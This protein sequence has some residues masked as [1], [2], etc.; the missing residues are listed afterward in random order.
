MDKETYNESMVDAPKCIDLFSGCGGFTCGLAK[1]GFNVVG[2]VEFDK[3]ANETYEFNKTSHGFPNS[4]RI[5]EDITKITDEEILAFK[6]KHGEI[7]VIV[8]GPPCQSFS[9]AG[10]RKLDDPRN[11]LFL[12]FVRFVKLIQ[13]KAFILENVPGLTSKKNEEGEFMID[14]IRQAF[15]KIGYETEYALINCANYEVPQLRRRIIIMGCKDKNKIAFP[16]PVTMDKLEGTEDKITDRKKQVQ[17]K[18]CQRCNKH[19]ASRVYLEDKT[20]ICIFCHEHQ[21]NI[22][23]NTFEPCHFKAGNLVVPKEVEVPCTRYDFIQIRNIETRKTKEGETNFIYSYYND[24]GVDRPYWSKPSE[25]RNVQDND[26]ECDEAEI[27]VMGNIIGKS[28]AQSLEE[29][30]DE[31]SENIEQD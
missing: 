28:I 13:P 9:L 19:Y 2:H 7:P 15:K 12:H 26:Q 11:N 20:T 18:R 24:G 22:D 14:I 8:G 3:S 1:A 25:Y 5:G 6:E 29:D 23:N 21:K 31:E 27:F 10:Q 30:E 17:L 4:E 16:L